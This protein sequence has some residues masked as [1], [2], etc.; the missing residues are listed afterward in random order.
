VERETRQFSKNRN[1]FEKGNRAN[2]ATHG[3]EKNRK[4]VGDLLI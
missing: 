3:T 1:G 4:I 2:H